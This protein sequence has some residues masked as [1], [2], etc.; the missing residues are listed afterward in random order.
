MQFYL[1]SLNLVEIAVLLRRRS[2]V[3]LYNM[4]IKKEGLHPRVSSVARSEI[5]SKDIQATLFGSATVLR[6]YEA[7]VRVPGCSACS[8]RRR[9][10]SLAK[11]KGGLSLPLFVKLEPIWACC[12]RRG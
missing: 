12:F 9:N 3:M 8:A 5:A 6:R 11:T 4:L 7:F 2:L 10:I 1:M